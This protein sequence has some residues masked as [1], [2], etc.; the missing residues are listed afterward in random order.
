MQFT[1]AH[2]EHRWFPRFLTLAHAPAVIGMALALVLAAGACAAAD[3]AQPVAAVPSEASPS[4][5]ANAHDPMLSPYGP[6]YLIF[7][8]EDSPATGDVTG[9]FQLSVKYDVGH[10]LYRAYTQRIYWDLTRNS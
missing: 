9:K 7:G 3:E 6:N 2:S 5:T 8:P 1:R 4:V 10:N